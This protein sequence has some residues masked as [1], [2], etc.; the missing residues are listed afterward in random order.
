M[1][2][3]GGEI[4]FGS[5]GLNKSKVSSCLHKVPVTWNDESLD[6]CMEYEGIDSD[7]TGIL[8][9][10]QTMDSGIC[11]AFSIHLTSHLH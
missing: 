1:H 6:S 11:N 3:D 5:F 10:S 2:E 4:S 9:S 7:A 8:A